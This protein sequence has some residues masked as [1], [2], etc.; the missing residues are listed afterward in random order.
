ME[1]QMKAI[2]IKA[3]IIGM[4]VATG[5]VTLAKTMEPDLT[6]SP[7]KYLKERQD[8]RSDLRN[9]NAN[10]TELADLKAELKA[11]KK[12]KLKMDVIVD[13]KEIAKTKADLQH[14][15][16]YLKADLKDLKRDHCLAVKEERK[17]VAAKRQ[18]LNEAKRD[19]RKDLRTDNTVALNQDAAEVTR[20]SMKYEVAKMALNAEKESYNNDMYVVYNEISTSKANYVA[21]KK[22]EKEETRTFASN[23]K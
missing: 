21:A 17:N 22:A 15:K 6:P 5:A 20:M 9:I 13:K 10:K 8:I 3:L 4:M 2:K 16:R 11:D 1:V 23:D 12:A 7:N 18:A 19:V 14:S